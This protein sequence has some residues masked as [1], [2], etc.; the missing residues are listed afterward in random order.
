MNNNVFCYLFGLAL[1]TCSSVAGAI[2]NDLT[3]L[4]KSKTFTT[5]GFDTSVMKK[6][7]FKQSEFNFNYGSLDVVTAGTV[8]FTYLGS[9]ASFTNSFV[10]KDSAKSSDEKGIDVFTNNG[11]TKLG[12]S[13]S[14]IVKK[15]TLKFDF[16]TLDPKYTVS[17]LD[18][19]TGSKT[20]GA[21]E[22]VFGI[23]Q[24]GKNGIKVGKNT[25]QDLLIYN[26]PLK[27]GSRDFNDLVVG[28]NFK[29][30]VSP[31]PEP[32]TYGMF[33]VGLGL[34]GFIAY[35]RKNDFSKLTQA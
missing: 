1:V 9:D 17:N 20:Y 11:A 28:V 21:N 13:F 26:D 2:S 24:G 10:F 18:P 23:V 22:G 35:R 4:D 30:L 34:I 25:F 15:G 5:S 8:T 16:T 27:T 29:P 3:V 6:D 33:L 32:E 19:K 31:V 14:E 12:S 7:G